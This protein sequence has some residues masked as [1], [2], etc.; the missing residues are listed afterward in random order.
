MMIRL[1]SAIATLILIGTYSAAAQQ[2]ERACTTT[3]NAQMHD[4]HFRLPGVE[5]GLPASCSDSGPVIA[6]PVSRR[7]GSPGEGDPLA[8][9]LFPPE[10]IMAHQSEIGLQDA[11]R[12]AITSEI[13]KAQAKFVE[14]QWRM[15][16]EAEHLQK[17]L[18]PSVADEAR[19][20]EQIDRT[21]AV[22]REIKRV[23]VTLL[24]RIKN[25]LTPSQQAKLADLRNGSNGKEI[26]VH[27]F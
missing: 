15:S 2:P 22:E 9:H 10:L 4:G 12:G 24:I 16:A 21:L 14:I 18:E 1:A 25:T 6:T 27:L 5:F 20:L 26:S 23:Q 3:D 8:S 7:G 19:V 17:L 11:Q 13:Q